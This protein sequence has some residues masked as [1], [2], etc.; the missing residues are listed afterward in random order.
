MSLLVLFFLI[1]SFR[2]HLSLPLLSFVYVWCLVVLLSYVSLAHARLTRH[3]GPLIGLMLF[4]TRFPAAFVL[5]YTYP[6]QLPL[7]HTVT[8]LLFTLS[9]R[10]TIS[11]TSTHTAKKMLL[12]SSSQSTSICTT[13]PQPS[14]ALLSHRSGVG[15]LFHHGPNNSLVPA[16]CHSWSTRAATRSTTTS[17]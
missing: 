12:Q 3:A 10:V 7:C 1:S 16:S 8:P 13:L 14:L 9:P 6:I 2:R 4:G 11:S 15:F 17:W 5:T